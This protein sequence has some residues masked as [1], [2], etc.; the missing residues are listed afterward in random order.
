M[1]GVKEIRT[2]RDQGLG[3]RDLA[4]S[5]QEKSGAGLG[6]MKID[7]CGSGDRAGDLSGAGPGKE[8][9]N[10]GYGIRGWVGSSKLD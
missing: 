4:E 6:Y 2:C 9:K 5:L 10:G 8:P 7:S 1:G 3:R